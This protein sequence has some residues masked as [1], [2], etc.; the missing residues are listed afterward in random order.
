MDLSRDWPYLEEVAATRLRNNKTQYH[1]N[2]YGTQIEIL[3]AAGELAARRFYGL[4]EGLHRGF[5]DGY[6]FKLNGY[7]VDVKATHLTKNI[8]HRFLQWPHFKPINADIILM[9]A[10]DLNKKK[11]TVL[12]YA[13][14]PE[15][16]VA[17]INYTRDVPCM[18]ISV[19]NLHPAW[20]LENLK[21][22]RYT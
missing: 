4:D 6:D 14:R 22:G 21:P 8:Q 13:T 9:T 7:R 1:I 11:A 10:I 20:H 16:E 18:E 15:V 17:P 3:G 2:K 5:D 19:S 12:G